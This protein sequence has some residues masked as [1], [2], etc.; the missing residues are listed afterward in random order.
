MMLQMIQMFQGHYRGHSAAKQLG[1]L[2]LVL[3]FW[4]VWHIRGHE[5]NNPAPHDHDCHIYEW[6]RSYRPQDCCHGN[7][8]RA[9]DPLSNDER[10]ILVLLAHGPPPNLRLK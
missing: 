3:G 5:W 6:H 1:L 10:P 2:Q 8:R 7:D 4:I 9:P